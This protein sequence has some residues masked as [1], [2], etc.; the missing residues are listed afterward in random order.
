MLAPRILHYTKRQIIWECADGL[1]FEASA[2]GDKEIGSGQIDWHFHKSNLQPYVAKAL[3]VMNPGW[4][5]VADYTGSYLGVKIT[6]ESL[7]QLRTW[8]QCVDEYSS[9]SLTIPTD[10]LHALAGVASVLN[11]NYVLG[12]YL[13]GLWSLR[14]AASLDW[15]RPWA[16]LSSPPVYTAPS[17][18]WASVNGAVS[19]SILGSH[20][21]ILLPPTDELGK[22]WAEMFELRLIKHHMVLQ[23]EF[24]PYGAVLE[25]SY[26]IVEGT[27]ITHKE[28][29]R[30]SEDI[31]RDSFSGP[32]IVLDRINTYD[33]PCCGPGR[34]EDKD[35]EN[36]DLGSQPQSSSLEPALPYDFC[37]LLIADAWRNPRGFVDMLLLRWVDEEAKVAE[38]VGLVRMAIWQGEEDLSH[39]DRRFR[40]GA[41]KRWTLK[42][43]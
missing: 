23:D 17:W 9:R 35:Y 34:Q 31:F 33:C 40:A 14:L 27:C 7:H 10:K 11:H 21:E 16:L 12:N 38:R 4:W 15:A 28:F 26:I 13:A 39:F 22:T 5:R 24:N 2:I 3:S 20:L 18:S 25:G 8:Q 43:V 42:L 6:L 30:L 37:L 32:T 19:S 29:V 41:W 1:K 36:V